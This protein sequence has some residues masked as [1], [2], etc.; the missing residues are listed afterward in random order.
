ML[1]V[2]VRENYEDIMDKALIAVS[3]N[4]DNFSI[5]F[6]SL[7]HTPMLKLGGKRKGVYQ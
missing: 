2:E 6:T 4:L 3:L 1:V 7:I 5:S